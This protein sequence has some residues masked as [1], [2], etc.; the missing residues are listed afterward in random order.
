MIVCFAAP[1]FPLPSGYL[2]YNFSPTPLPVKDL[3]LL[4]W[5]S[6]KLL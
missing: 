4:W 6:I 1:W 3:R 5:W 2:L